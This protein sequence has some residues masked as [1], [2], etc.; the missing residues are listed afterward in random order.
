MLPTILAVF[1]LAPIISAFRG[2]GPWLGSVL[3]SV[4]LGVIAVWLFAR[5]ARRCQRDYPEVWRRL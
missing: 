3:G 5:L 2:K 1:A 4:A